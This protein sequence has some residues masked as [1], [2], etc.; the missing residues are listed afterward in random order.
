MVFS[1]APLKS[2]IYLPVAGVNAQNVDVT[3]L[4][5]A[6][7]HLRPHTN[8]L[9]YPEAKPALLN[10]LAQHRQAVALPGTLGMMNKVTHHIALQPGAQPSYV[11]SY[12]LPHS[13]RQ[14][15]QQKVDKL[16]RSYTRVPFSLELAAL[17]G[18]EKGWFLLP[19]H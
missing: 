14:V 7:A 17:L 6:M 4:T 9:D 15:V 11:P 12:Q 1:L 10:L 3:D 16:T 19:C 5:D 13:Q 18:S 8:I 2:L